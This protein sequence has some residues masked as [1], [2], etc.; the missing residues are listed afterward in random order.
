MGPRHR[1]WAKPSNRSLGPRKEKPEPAQRLCLIAGRRR[2]KR[3]FAV[4]SIL[5]ACHTVPNGLAMADCQS[6]KGK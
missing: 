2:S 5:L 4:E 1:S 3:S 6:W